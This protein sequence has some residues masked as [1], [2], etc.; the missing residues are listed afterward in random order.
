MTPAHDIR[1]CG[2]APFHAV[3]VEPPDCAQGILVFVRFVIIPSAAEADIT[4]LGSALRPDGCGG[5]LI[6]PGEVVDILGIP[7]PR[8]EDLIILVRTATY[9]VCPMYIPGIDPARELDFQV[10]TAGMRRQWILDDMRTLDVDL[11]VPR[12]VEVFVVANRSYVHALGITGLRQVHLP[13]VD[14]VARGIEVPEVGGCRHSRNPTRP[15]TGGLRRSRT[16]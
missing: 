3:R 16:G 14:R 11:K 9:L 5:N 13:S 15:S 7:S 12:C 10:Q 2:V 6:D 4:I 8:V 1:V